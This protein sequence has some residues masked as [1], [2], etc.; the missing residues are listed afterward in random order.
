LKISAGSL[1]RKNLQ[2]ISRDTIRP[3]SSVVKKALFNIIADR[4]PDSQFLDLFA[5]SG[6]IGFEAFS[7]G[8]AHVSFIEKDDLLCRCLKENIMKFAN[9]ESQFS[10]FHGHFM[11]GL[12]K[13]VRLKKKFDFIFIDPPYQTDSAL[14]AFGACINMQLIKDSSC[15]ILECSKH[16]AVPDAQFLEKNCVE[17]TD[18]R[19][20]G[21][22]RLY[23]YRRVKCN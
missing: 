22:T 2:F 15:V 1:K 23:F 13:L 20:Y 10:V 12:G 17:L 11:S 3:T 7:R 18:E 14:K 4:L 9:C 21:M 5:G 16:S 8:A 6:S 19:K